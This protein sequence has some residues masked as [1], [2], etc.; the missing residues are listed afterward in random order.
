MLERLRFYLRH[1]LNDL[2]VGG[3]LTF[4]AL[5][6]IAAGVAAVVSLQTLGLMIGDTLVSN[7]QESNRGDISLRLPIPEDDQEETRALLERAVD[8]GLVT[9]RVGGFLFARTSFYYLSEE[10]V[11]ALRAW[12]DDRYPGQI[13]MDYSF[14]ISD[15]LSRFLGTGAG[16][17]MMVPDSGSEVTQ[18]TPI[19]VSPERYPFYGRVVTMGGASL[20]ERI[21]SPTDVV[22]DTRVAQA[23]D[24][25]IGDSVRIRGSSRD[26]TV[27]GIVTTEQE[28]RDP[29][30][31]IQVALFGFYYL[32][33]RAIDLFDG[34]R[35]Q[36][37]TL[38]LKLAQPER[39]AEIDAALRRDFP[40]LESTTTG[41]LE[42]Q[43][44]RLSRRI[45]QLVTIMGLISLLVG[46]IGIM[47]TMQ[48]VVRRRTLEIAVLKTVGVRNDQVTVM[49][50]IEA[51]L[52]GL[53]GSLAGVVLGW[54]VTLLLKRIAEVI[55]A[56]QLPYRLALGPAM[57]GLVVGTLIAT[58]FG[59]LPTLSAGLVRPV[60]VL[61]PSENI[62]PRAGL[63]RI[64][65]SLLL[66]LLAISLVA[67]GILG[68]FRIAALV[69]LGA[70]LAAGLLYL[71]LLA[72]VWLAGRVLPLLG[73]VD[74]KIPMRQMLAVRARAAS[75]LLALV[76]GVF[77]LSLITL[78]A[79]SIRKLLDVGIAEVGGNVLVTA[80]GERQRQVIEELLREQPGV[81]SYTV[82][83]LYQAKLLAVE[84]AGSGRTLSLEDLGVRIA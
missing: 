71:L 49:F 75:T 50:L 79:D 43:N 3:R 29:A 54:G 84:D 32:D 78:M 38:W 7:L 72:L 83:L 44:E 41:D 42:Q 74:L 40:F 2:R 18:L 6:S 16:G 39:V 73:W 13:E 48:V 62:L 70:F 26:F 28:V 52:M 14:A 57:S 8:E 27:R 81:R 24:A 69:T 11:G 65:A 1:S 9:V 20:K 66:V 4:F 59:F 12:L 17:A 31:S 67:R 60:L 36:V 19:L 45:R 35:P 80:Q 58:I 56:Q 33:N 25:R 15:P 21:L 76:I 55:V 47:N 37:E 61:R 10:G 64:A 82:S 68:D 51:L 5:L 23:L 77:S 22:I 46:S 53:F 34:V 63:L 30:S